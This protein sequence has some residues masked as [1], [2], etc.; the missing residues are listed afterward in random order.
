[1]TVRRTLLVAVCSLGAAAAV[2]WWTAPP[3]A[4]P[5]PEQGPGD[6]EWFR[7]RLANPETGEI[8]ADARE[9]E[10]A[11]ARALPSAGAAARGPALQFVSLGP[12]DVG[13]RT[14]A[15]AVDR[16]APDV[17]L[18]GAVSGG[19]WR[20][21]DRGRSLTRVTRLDQPFN[22]TAIVQDVRPGRG[23]VWYA[24]TGEEIGSAYRLLHR[25]V[26]RSLDGGRT[27]DELSSITPASSIW[28][29][30]VH[31]T[32]E[33]DVLFAATSLGISR[34]V[35][36]G[37]SWA[38]AL[39]AGWSSEV[40]VTASGTVY[41]TTG[42]SPDAAPAVWRSTDAGAS[43]TDISP[44]DMPEQMTRGVLG[45]APSDESVLY[46]L[47]DTPRSGLCR[48]AYTCKSLWKL[49]DGEAAVWENRSDNLDYSAA[50]PSAEARLRPFRAYGPYNLEV[51]VRPDDPDVVYVG[52]I[53]LLRS[54][55]G[56]ASTANTE[57]ITNHHLDQ[58]AVV[59]DPRDPARLYVGSDGGVHTATDDLRALNWPW[60]FEWMSRNEGY[61]TT[62]FYTVALS[63]EGPVEVLGGTQDNGTWW[64]GRGR[65]GSP[66]GGD[67]SFAAFTPDHYYTSSQGGQVYRLRR[68]GAGWDGRTVVTPAQARDGWF[69]HPYAIDP[70]DPDVM[71]YPSG[72]A[73]WRNDRLGE[74][75][76]GNAEPT[77][78]GWS[79]VLEVPPFE[80]DNGPF[81]GWFTALGVA[82]TPADRVYVADLNGRVFR[83]DGADGP[84]P[85]VTE[86]SRPNPER[87]NVYA[88]SVAVDPAD[89]DHV[90]VTYS[91]FFTP[92]VYESW[93]GGET[94][95]DVSGN[96][97]RDTV[98]GT[99]GPS[100]S[101]AEML[102]LEGGGTRVYLATTVGLLSADARDGAAT[103]WSHE[104]ADV[105]G[106]AQ[107]DMVDVRLSDGTL[108]VGTHGSGVF[109]GTPAGGVAREAGPAAAAVALDMVYPN[110]LGASQPA[111]V[112]FTLGQPGRAAVRVFDVR[113]R[114]VARLDDRAWPVG[115]HHVEWRAP[116]AAGVYVV[117]VR[118]DG[119]S[120]T[121]RVTVAGR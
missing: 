59:F 113:G 99:T 39:R 62:Q 86:L 100:V 11:V 22:V 96:I 37:T 53:P 84:S 111:T 91:N 35:D 9:A 3:A 21:T 117:E 76:E 116:V 28:G 56:F 67:G 81:S 48:G 17:V 82:S 73:L 40:V 88:S 26:L 110:P 57:D 114:E 121:K 12:V 25:V 5:A 106:Y 44:P 29:L 23:H 7:L 50:P 107:V 89:G 1:M 69:L 71:Y 83:V 75:P 60:E 103:V 94:W 68:T 104:G 87:S 78:V 102:P 4:P 34:S 15:L 108:A 41:A 120:Q 65:W 70:S 38:L 66:S 6:E 45:L 8:P 118:V 112:R 115:T 49:T 16:T 98:T 90:V 42:H 97:A 109:L 20:S 19:I 33:A 32:T 119:Q 92:S 14:R 54:T 63:P 24:G 85:A 58:H 52:G 47:A 30:A 105:L 95:T 79:R 51:A 36:G 18:A 101:W 80:D 27:W 72:R 2:L 77:P 43:W 93:D 64:Y 10:L 31:P 13:G 61:V 46:L 55:D 74:I